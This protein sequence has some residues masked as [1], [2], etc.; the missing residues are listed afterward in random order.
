MSTSK[1]SSGM[2]LFVAND[3]N[4][5]WSGRI[6]ASNAD[7]TDGPFATL[8]RARDEI[9]NIKQLGEIPEG[10]VTVELR[11]GVYQREQPFEL[12]EEDSGNEN[13][14]VMYRAQQGEEVRLLGGKVVVGFE[15]VTDPAIS[16]R[17]SPEARDNVLQ[18]DLGTLG[19]SDFGEVKGG[20]LEF[21][22]EDKPM[23]LARWPNEGFVRIVDL[24]GGDPVDVRGTKG[25]KIGKFMYEGDRPKRWGEENDVW[26]HGYWF[27]DWSDQRHKVE[28]ID[29]GRRII[30]VVPPYHGYGYRKGQWF[31][32]LNILAELDVPGEWY[33]DR[34]AGILYFW[35]PAP[36]EQ[37]QPT[38]SVVDT[39]VKMENV[40]YVTFC[41]MTFEAA[42]GTAITISGGT[43]NRIVGCTLR[44]LGSW[45]VN[46][47]GGS[48]NGVV[49]CDIYE[50]GN[51]GITLSGGERKALSPAGHYA[52]N[53]HIHHY[54]RWNRMY[55]SAISMSGV[56][57]RAS[58]NLIHNA[59]HMAIGFSGNDHLIE[60]NEIHS[61]CYESNDAGAMYSGRDWTMRGTIIRHNFLHHI[62]GF[63]GRGCVG[64]YLDDM[65][66]GTTIYG[67]L[68]YKV[69]RAAFI[70][71]GRDCIVENNIFV[72][73]NP[74]LHIDARAMGWASYHVGTTMKE[75][76]LAMPYKEALWTGR[77]PKLVGIWEDEPAA[78]KGNIV[79]R[80]I[81]QGGRWDGVQDQARTYVTFEDN[82]VDEEPGFVETPPKS[83]QLRDDS[84]AYELGFKPIPIEKIGLYEDEERA[85]WPVQ[86]EVRQTSD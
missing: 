8:E 43:H 51:G 35:P 67:N 15:P 86:H 22:F 12:S 9:R 11:G 60:F 76:L 48:H 28:S 64:V 39:L 13:A 37:G 26:V 81:S 31:Y 59:P 63:E 80:N 77:Y 66:C 10:G 19:I 65:L 1:K 82:L 29:A 56:G 7:A 30:S 71:G 25:D 14:P 17:L 6:S 33:L 68:F 27:W 41:G 38:V 62:S 55:Q 44:N 70:G 23:T 74:A 79:A 54:G 61:V 16:E 5:T 34:E 46:I 53:N 47:S 32:G 78:P 50:T 3:G 45:A 42:R 73:C 69:T 18:A 4:D 21:F 85:S 57:N 83:F 75:R 24:V 49:G 20:G 36:I 40:A 52:E 84:Q 58:H 72:D 2:T